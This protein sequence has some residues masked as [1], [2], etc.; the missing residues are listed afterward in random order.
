MVAEAPA[1]KLP[2]TKLINKRSIGFSTRAEVFLAD[3]LPLEK[4]RYTAEE[5]SNS[6]P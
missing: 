6:R 1:M 2:K 5:F 4:K 3:R